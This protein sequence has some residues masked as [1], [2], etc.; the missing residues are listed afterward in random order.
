[1]SAVEVG[2]RG[3]APDR[4]A[5]PGHPRVHRRARRP[6]A[7][8]R[9]PSGTRRTRG[10][11]PG[12][13]HGVPVAI[14][15]EVDVAGC[16]TTFGGRGNRT[17][18]TADSEVVRRLRAAGAVVVGKTAMPEFGAWPFTE[19]VAHGV[20]RNPW[21]RGTRRAGPAAAPRP[22]SPRG[23]VPV[24]SAA[25]AAG[26]SGSP[27][28]AAACSGS[29][30]SAAG[31]RSA[32]MEHLWWALGTVGPL[33]RSVATAALV[34]DVV[35]GSRPSDL[36]RAGEPGS[37]ADAA[38]AEPGPAAGRVVDQAGHARRATR[39]RA[40]PR[41]RATPRSCSRGSATRCGGRP[42]LPRPQRGVRAAV[43][44]RRP[45]RGGRGRAARAARAAHPRDLRLGAWVRPGWSGLGAGGAGE[46]VPGEPGLRPAATCCSPRRSRTGRPRSAS[47][48]ASAPSAPP[49]VRPGDRLHRAVERRRQPGGVGAGGRRRRR[50]AAG[51]AAGRPH[52]RRADRAGGLGQL[53]REQPRAARRPGP[54]PGR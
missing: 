6:G 49:C 13:L 38:A 21:S 50:P 33:A 40:R 7:A 53:E 41:R 16:V 11:A 17:P 9:R 34:Y 35:R 45:Q 25:T 47:S 14:K 43:L 27:R 1:M 31:S 51:G 36:Y 15:E 37:F 22:R 19:S 8:P 32:P 24:A 52:R 54:E 3:A 26:R 42:P 20:T 12:P 28:R 23:M 44:R 18:V 48:T 5:G 2:R 39:P 29:S 46:R 10:R 4:R 30:R